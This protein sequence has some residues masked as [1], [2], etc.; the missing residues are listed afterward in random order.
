MILSYQ[1]ILYSENLTCID[2]NTLHYV[3]AKIGDCIREKYFEVIN[4]DLLRG[5]V[6]NLKIK[7]PILIEGVVPD[8]IPYHLL[9]DMVKRILRR[10]GSMIYLPK[11]IEI[12]DH[13]LEWE[14]NISVQELEE[15]I[16]TEIKRDDNFKCVLAARKS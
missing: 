3:I 13:V 5:L 8:K 16:L 6:D 7:Y 11:I 1:N 9:T 15:E 14:K 10:G 4:P 12:M 2:E